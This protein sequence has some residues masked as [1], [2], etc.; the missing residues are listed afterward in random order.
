MLSLVLNRFVSSSVTG[1]VTTKVDVYSFGV[2]LMELLT[3]L[4]ALDEH[5][6]EEQRYLAEWFWRIKSEKEKLIA[7]IDPALDAKEDIYESVYTIAELAGHCTAR[8]PSQRPDMGYVVN[9]LARL[10]DEWKPCEEDTDKDL[11]INTELPLPQMLKGW[12]EDE[13]TR[14]FSE[15]STQG[16]KGSIPSKPSG[17]ADT[18]T[19]NDAR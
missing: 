1:K 12:K 13:V 9:V 2:V 7:N 10:V 14:D 8:D 11:G 15:S 5:R 6:P 17:F 19:S 18:F 16:S 3:G 4:A